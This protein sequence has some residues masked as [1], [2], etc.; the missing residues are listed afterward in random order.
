MEEK[1]YPILE[2]AVNRI[3]EAVIETINKDAQEQYELNGKGQNN[4]VAG[5]AMLEVAYGLLALPIQDLL[6]SKIEEERDHALTLL[7]QAESIKNATVHVHKLVGEVKGVPVMAAIVGLT[8]G[9]LTLLHEYS[10]ELEKDLSGE[11]VEVPSE[12][13]DIL[14]N[15][16]KVVSEDE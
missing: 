15:F 11:E 16:N 10:E 13:K 3:Q 2:E 5:R 6:G 7:G 12:V 4:L 8:E 14:K 1:E 9:L